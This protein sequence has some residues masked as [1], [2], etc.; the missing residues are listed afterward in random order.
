[1]KPNLPISDTLERDG[2]QFSI[3]ID[4]ITKDRKQPI[5]AWIITTPNSK[6]AL[7]LEMP[8]DTADDATMFYFKQITEVLRVVR[9]Q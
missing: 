3:Y 2:Y 6:N 7:V 9:S 4:P 1:M 8:L 5:V